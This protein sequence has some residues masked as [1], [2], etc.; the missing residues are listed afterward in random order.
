MARGR[1]RLGG[2]GRV[3]G[4]SPS[5]RLSEL[6]IILFFDVVDLRWVDELSEEEWDRG[7][8]EEG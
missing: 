8:V 2:G 1:R 5:S 6:P 3:A 4:I 7:D